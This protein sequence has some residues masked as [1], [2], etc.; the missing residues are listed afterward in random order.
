MGFLTGTLDDALIDALC[1][2]QRATVI[3]DYAEERGPGCAARD[4]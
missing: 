2:S 3:I 4:A 1:T